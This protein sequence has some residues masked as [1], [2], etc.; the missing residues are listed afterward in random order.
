MNNSS[1]VST[2]Q[3]LGHL[4]YTELSTP[5]G[6]LLLTATGQGLSSIE[7]GPLDQVGDRLA[8][9]ALRWY[10]TTK[11][12]REETAMEPYAAQLREYFAGRR[13][14]FDL[15]LD[16]RGTPFQRRV[17]RALTEI[18]YGERR[19]YKEIAAMIGSPKAVRAVGGANNRNPLPI[20]VPCHRVVGADGSLV[21]YGGGMPIKVFLLQLEEGQSVASTGGTL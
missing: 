10:G 18:P 17:W 3:A 2:E 9:W 20:V 7:F 14:A 13:T 4:L 1:T 12:V 5:I 6:R 19:S 15:P 21:G 8:A 16:L 11:L